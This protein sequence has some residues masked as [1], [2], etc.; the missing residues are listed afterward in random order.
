MQKLA[1]MVQ[2]NERPKDIIFFLIFVPQK[3][4]EL[5]FAWV[6]GFICKDVLSLQ[7]AFHEH[8]F[9]VQIWQPNACHVLQQCSI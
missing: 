5:I 8:V 7:N 4:K 1:E 3:K 9:S 6:Y 2:R